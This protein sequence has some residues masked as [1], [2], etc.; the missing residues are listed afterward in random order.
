MIIRLKIKKILYIKMNFVNYINIKDLN[1][2]WMENS[3]FKVRGNICCIIRM[4]VN[5][6]V[7]SLRGVF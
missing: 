1:L 6:G 4:P 2:W 3:L 7:P 5:L